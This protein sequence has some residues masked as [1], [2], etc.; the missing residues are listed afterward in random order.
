MFLKCLYVQSV[1]TGIVNISMKIWTKFL[2]HN[3]VGRMDIRQKENS[4]NGYILTKYILFFLIEK[5][6][7]TSWA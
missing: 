2:P 7:G 1:N 5:V 4:K 6:L 3:L